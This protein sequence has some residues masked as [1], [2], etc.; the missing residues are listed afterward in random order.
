MRAAMS[1][2]NQG[3]VSL[4]PSG[5]KSKQRCS[6]KWLVNKAY[7]QRPPET[8]EDPFYKDP[9]GVDHLKPMVVRGLATAEL[10]CL[11]LSNIYL[12]P[13]YA[14]LNH[15]G[16]IQALARKGVYVAEPGDVA[17]T[18][19]VLIQT[20][21]VK[22]SAHMAVIEALLS[23][24]VKEVVSGR[25]M[26]TVLTRLHHP[27]EAPESAEEGLLCWLNASCAKLEEGIGQ[28]MTEEKEATQALPVA[29][30]DVH[31]ARLEVLLK[32]KTDL[33]PPH[34]PTV[35]E[36]QDLSDGV[37][38][39]AVL[40]LYL[41]DHFDWSSLVSGSSLSMADSVHNLRMVTGF[42]QA[43]TVLSHNP[44][45]FTVEDFLYSHH[46]IR[47]NI[48]AFLADLFYHLEVKPVRGVRTPGTKYERISLSPKHSPMKGISS[49]HHRS[50]PEVRIN[51]IPDLRPSVNNSPLAVAAQA[52]NHWNKHSNGRPRR[53]RARSPKRPSTKMFVCAHSPPNWNAQCES[54]AA[55]KQSLSKMRSGQA[56][57]RSL[58]SE[59][60]RMSWDWAPGLSP[61]AR[62]LSLSTSSVADAP[63]TAQR[64]SSTGGSHTVVSSATRKR[65][66]KKRAPTA[67]AHSHKP[68][69]ALTVVPAQGPLRS[70]LPTPPTSSSRSDEG[71]AYPCALSPLTA[72][73]E[74][75]RPCTQERLIALATPLS[76]DPAFSSPPTRPDT[77]HS[78][79]SFYLFPPE[80]TVMA[81]PMV[82]FLST[83]PPDSLD[84]VAVAYLTGRGSSNRE[85]EHFGSETS[86]SDENSSLDIDD[87]GASS[88]MGYRRGD[89]SGD[90]R[91]HR[92]YP[93]AGVPT[94][95]ASR[96]GSSPTSPPIPSAASPWRAGRRANSIT[97]NSQLTLANFGGGGLHASTGAPSMP[98]PERESGPSSLSYADRTMPARERRMSELESTIALDGHPLGPD[99]ETAPER[100][101][102]SSIS[103]RGTPSS[104]RGSTEDAAGGASRTSFAELR[105]S[106]SRI[107]LSFNNAAAEE[108]SNGAHPLPPGPG[109][110]SPDVHRAN[111][112]VNSVRLKL[113]E[114]RRRIEAEKRK[115]EMAFAKEKSKLGKNAFLQALS[116]KAPPPSESSPENSTD[117]AC[118]SGNPSGTPPP[119]V[120]SPQPS[121]VT[122]S[123]TLP[124]MT[125]S[126]ATMVDSIDGG[127]PTMQ[128]SSPVRKLPQVPKPFSLMD[129]TQEAQEVDK[130]WSTNPLPDRRPP[131]MDRMD[132]GAYQAGFM[133]RLSPSAS[134]A[135]AAR[136][137]Q[138]LHDIQA[139]IARL[140][141]LQEDLQRQLHEQQEVYQPHRPRRQWGPVSNDPYYEP[142]GPLSPHH[143]PPG[144]SPRRTWG[145]PQQF[146]P[147]PNVAPPS[148]PSNQQWAYGPPYPPA[149]WQQGYPPPNGSGSPYLPAYGSP[150]AM[151]GGPYS[152]SM[153]G[154]P[155]GTRRGAPPGAPPPSGAPPQQIKELFLQREQ[156]YAPHS[157]FRLHSSPSPATLARTPSQ[158][159]LPQPL[160]ASPA[161]D[162]AQAPG[163]RASPHRSL[164]RD[165]KPIISEAPLSHVHHHA[166]STP[167]RNSTSPQR[168][169]P[170]R[171]IAPPTTTPP[172]S[173]A[174]ERPLPSSSTNGKPPPEPSTAHV[175][176]IER[177]RERIEKLDIKS[178]SRT[179]RISSSD[180]PS[181]SPSPHASLLNQ[182]A[183]GS[184]ARKPD[185]G[186]SQESEEEDLPVLP[187]EPLKAGKPAEQGFFISFDDSPSPASSPARPSRT[188]ASSAAANS[189]P[190]SSSTPGR[191]A[192]WVRSNSRDDATATQPARPSSRV[193]TPS[194]GGR[195]CKLSDLRSADSPPRRRDSDDSN[196][197]LS[198]PKSVSSPTPVD[199]RTYARSSAPRASSPAASYAS[200]ATV[201]GD[202]PVQE[203]LDLAHKMSLTSPVPHGSGPLS[204][205]AEDRGGWASPTHAPP[206][207]AE[208]HRRGASGV[209][210][211]IGP[212]ESTLDPDRGGW[213]SPTHAPPGGA[214]LQRRGASGV[215]LVIGPDESTLDPNTVD[216]M[217][218]RKE[219][220]L[221]NSMKR[222]ARLEE[223]K[224]EK[225]AENARKKDEEKRKEEEK[226]RK[227]E[228]EKLKR[229]LLLEQYKLRKAME[230]AEDEGRPMPHSNGVLPS[231]KGRVIMSHSNGVLPSSKGRVTSQGRQGQSS[232]H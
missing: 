160:D 113:E 168:A 111:A 171:H 74:Q 116:N 32:E 223:E 205:S 97:D 219:R 143:Y 72:K 25:R 68:A 227:K 137:S 139:D 169:T 207:G 232:A 215:G 60:L 151:E 114:K 136:V 14:Q 59:R 107:N 98:Q 95:R 39:G 46:S 119:P 40:S 218:R 41:P 191:P 87:P 3:R 89:S 178:G 230:K 204:P 92:E 163:S 57:R 13:N 158:T 145:S 102:Q 220:I 197:P 75:H 62:R 10:Y 206:G 149:E 225:E 16:V 177:A 9:E 209:G 52:E 28:L 6:L 200:S 183:E 61:A 166:H 165:D 12:D 64:P 123:V 54:C 79:S 90:G 15:W 134:F 81:A 202:Q 1:E 228:E 56:P 131:D 208:L 19:T 27:M 66:R 36:I 38:L 53:T 67:V 176:D 199:S 2:N 229:E 99:G 33:T 50:M 121:C 140:T 8:M 152:V 115:M 217:E 156:Q 73:R 181:H 182:G 30:V 141:R 187:V 11:T 213:A 84:P 17:L 37:A 214:E 55:Q 49:R 153:Y 135:N 48:L 125:T 109:P 203:L 180:R 157:S 155:G 231:S 96:D 196:E 130:R 162:D 142:K 78:S 23:L 173:S 43:R 94:P 71:G 69:T 172:S 189:T 104:R 144:T 26:E 224:R 190:R 112:E 126:L 103:E 83:T 44:C 128:V 132:M 210:L 192:P 5:V 159:A 91:S 63:S 167:A 101:R 175:P 117:T 129:L 100:T 184:P 188:P 195:S 138:S 222:K 86:P 70:G 85:R 150:Y 65:K 201:D 185:G 4:T 105:L 20:S 7:N 194:S 31:G 154:G 82:D 216:E 120:S 35:Q 211:V 146:R 24:Y 118:D 110:H 186:G 18:E 148:L 76:L 170:P 193:S 88:S 124:E 212:D 22:M 34:Y 42:F 80:P 221:K 21:P 51:S 198:L 226:K 174:N 106:N 29:F 161:K 179:Y 77:E 127:L 133:H 122:S 164:S 93:P 108:T 45:V 58:S 47:Q 147:P